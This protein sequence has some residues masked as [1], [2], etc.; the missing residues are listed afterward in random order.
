MVK[1]HRQSVPPETY[2]RDYY[3]SHCH[4]FAEFRAWRGQIVDSRLE[5]PMQLADVTPDMFVLDVGCGRGEIVVQT[6]RRGAQVVGFDYSIAAVETAVAAISSLPDATRALVHLGDALYLPY[7][8]NLFD[9]VFML[10]VVEHLYP[11]ELSECLTE[12]M[13]VLRPSGKL[14]I[15]TM[16]NIWYYRYGYP[17]FRAVQWLRGKRLPRDPRDRWAY[18]DVHVNEQSMVSLHRTLLAAGFVPRVWLKSIHSYDE[19]P[20][21]MLR[22]IMRMTAT[23]YPFRLIFCDDLFAVAT[24]PAARVSTLETKANANRD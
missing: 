1:R 18:K 17:V 24:K 9:R 8:S 5:I 19:E 14:V 22:S 2:T 20:N 6:A 21:A 23:V 4:G 13:R 12:V 7:S 16:P 10:D 3:E 11:A 15:H